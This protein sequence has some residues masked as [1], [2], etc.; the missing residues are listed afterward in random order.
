MKS[1]W[2]EV[3]PTILWLAEALVSSVALALLHSPLETLPG[4]VTVVP[5]PGAIIMS[6]LQTRPANTG[7]GCVRNSV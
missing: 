2:P 3:P 4:V 1:L 6:V 7:G 5:I